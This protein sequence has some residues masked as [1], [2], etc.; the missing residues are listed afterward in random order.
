MSLTVYGAALS[1][2][3]RKVLFF[4][5][6]KGLEYQLENIMPGMLPDWYLEINPLGR[7]PSLRDGDLDLSDSAIICHY[8]QRKY[9]GKTNLLGDTPAEKAKVEWFEKYADYEVAPLA[10]FTVFFNRTL[11]PMMGKS[12]DE[13]K[14]Q[15]ALSK[16]PKHF[17]YLETQLNG[18]EYFVGNRFTLADIAVATQWINFEYA[19]ERL[20]EQ[21]WPNL[22]AHKA[23]VFG[24][25]AGQK[26]LAHETK[27]LQKL[28]V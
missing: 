4:I 7:I 10:T 2:F 23:R 5:E 15:Q 27:I 6:E 24:R 13:E 20:D 21:R 25:E 28:G 17:D 8:L 22:V 26:R 3:V 14:V 11:M 19:K 16:L 9:G 18:N 1:P 12:C